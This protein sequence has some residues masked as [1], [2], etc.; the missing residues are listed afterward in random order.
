MHY[1]CKLCI[2]RTAVNGM[3]IWPRTDII[4]LSLYSTVTSSVI[5]LLLA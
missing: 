5:A 3:I 1:I 4:S 2:I